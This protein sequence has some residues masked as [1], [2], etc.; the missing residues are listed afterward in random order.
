[1]TR[2]CWAW[3]GGGGGGHRS[4]SVRAGLKGAGEGQPQESDRSS[5]AS[6]TKASF[7]SAGGGAPRKPNRCSFGL[8]TQSLLGRLCSPAFTLEPGDETQ[9]F[10]A[11]L[12]VMMTRWL[13]C[14][15]SLVTS[16]EQPPESLFFSSLFYLF[17][18]VL[19]DGIPAL[20][21]STT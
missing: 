10:G 7:F 18:L 21:C 4:P 1:M 3:G 11:G 5:S 19:N 15:L 13:H 2:S 16:G 17:L 8:R 12:P 6:R 20:K 9:E 14:L